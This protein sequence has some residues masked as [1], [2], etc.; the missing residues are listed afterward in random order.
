MVRE[1]PLIGSLL[2]P[3]AEKIVVKENVN[4]IMALFLLM[5]TNRY[6][7]VLFDHV[8]NY[9]DFGLRFRFLSLEEYPDQFDIVAVWKKS[10]RTDTV[11]AMAESLQEAVSERLPSQNTLSSYK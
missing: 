2:A 6:V 5:N 3:I 8:R 7:T 1:A 9:E 11:V 4:D 10:S